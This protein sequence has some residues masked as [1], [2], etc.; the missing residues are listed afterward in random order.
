MHLGPL[1]DTR[2]GYVRVWRRLIVDFYHRPE[3]ELTAFIST[4]W[5]QMLDPGSNIYHES[6][7]YW[8]S[9]YL[10][11]EHLPASRNRTRLCEALCLIVDRY[12]RL[13]RLDPSCFPELRHEI[14]A[15]IAEWI[16]TKCS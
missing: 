6:P 15:V 10:L 9:H 13:Y 1:H 16:A 2:D 8:A 14:D 12:D 11:P 7:A 5:D 3:S 4:W